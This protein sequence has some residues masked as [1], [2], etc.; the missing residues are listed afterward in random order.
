MT[1]TLALTVFN[2]VDYS[3]VRTTLRRYAN[4]SSPESTADP[5]LALLLDFLSRPARKSLVKV[6]AKQVVQAYSTDQSPTILVEHALSVHP[7]GS[8]LSAS[9]R[10]SVVESVKDLYPDLSEDPF[11]VG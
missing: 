9:W 1:M 4:P 11:S 8:V 5:R 7:L 3:S 10:A 2:P 6:I